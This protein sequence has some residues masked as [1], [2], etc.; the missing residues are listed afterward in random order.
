MGGERGREGEGD[1]GVVGR[2]LSDQ[3]GALYCTVYTHKSK[4]QGKRRGGG[5]IQNKIREAAKK[6]F[7][8]K[9]FPNIRQ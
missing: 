8:A 4:R 9:K 3:I 6:K 7:P 5:M 2:K 1:E